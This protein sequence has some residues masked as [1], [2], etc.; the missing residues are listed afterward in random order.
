MFQINIG[1]AQLHQSRRGDMMP[2]LMSA[3]TPRRIQT[4]TSDNTPQERLSAVRDFD[5]TTMIN[6]MH[7]ELGTSI[8]RLT[9]QCQQNHIDLNTSI[10]QLTQECNS[11]YKELSRDCKDMQTQIDRQQSTPEKSQLKLHQTGQSFTRTAMDEHETPEAIVNGSVNS[12]RSHSVTKIPP[13]L[14]PTESTYLYIYPMRRE[15]MRNY[16][17]DATDK[18]TTMELMKKFS[19]LQGF[20]Q[21][22]GYRELFEK[23]NSFSNSQQMMTPS[24]RQKTDSQ[25]KASPRTIVDGTNNATIP[26]LLMLNN[27]DEI[28]NRDMTRDKIPS[29]IRR[30]G[31]P[32]DTSYSIIEYNTTSPWTCYL[33]N[34]QIIN[35]NQTAPKIF[36]RR[37]G[38]HHCTIIPSPVAIWNRIH[39]LMDSDLTN[40]KKARSCAAKVHWLITRNLDAIPKNNIYYIIQLTKDGKN[41]SHDAQLETIRRINKKGLAKKSNKDAMIEDRRLK[42]RL[43]GLDDEDMIGQSFFRRTAMDEHETPEA[44]DR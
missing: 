40:P 18:A 11:M 36:K 29:L 33:C 6:N 16:M 9:E 30:I 17:T 42:R 13:T 22:Q 27:I 21:L 2:A 15:K 26:I 20:G 24:K 31:S 37:M 1:I 25:N 5:I 14:L 32:S 19:S 4:T 44:I 28:R 8:E 10:S 34:A 43:S 41:L 3:M 7:S 38:K 39:K 23:D 35:H 12:R